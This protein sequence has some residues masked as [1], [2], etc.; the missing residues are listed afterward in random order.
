MEEF[1]KKHIR[2]N[3]FVLYCRKGVGL[4]NEFRNLIL[5]IIAG[6]YAI[7]ITSVWIMILIFL[8]SLPVLMAVGWYSLHYMD[9][10]IEELTVKYAT[11]YARR[12]YDTMEE[13]KDLLKKLND[14]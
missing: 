3:T 8:V 12:Q 10:I 1:S 13:I 4:L 5:L 6:C 7:Q 9:K 11:K 14:K 2:F